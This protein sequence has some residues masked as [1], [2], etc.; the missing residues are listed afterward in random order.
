VATLR[1]ARFLSL[2]EAEGPGR[3]CA[4]WLQGC[5]LC[6]PGCCNPA[7]WDPAGGREVAVEEL[8]GLL[9]AA[10]GEVEGL[11]LLGGEPFLQA[12]GAAAVARAARAL[13]L[14]VVTFTGHR[15]EELVAS[16]DPDTAALLAATDLLVDGPYLAQEPERER[17]WAGSANQRFHYLTDRYRPGLE[18]PG[19]G[20]PQE[21][22]EVHLGAD[23]RLLRSGWPV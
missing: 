6:C 15:R 23:G 13:G 14:S 9:R 16:P 3:R 19:P 17:R 11:T 20:E 8:A 5:R 22:V 10:R 21:T 7:M 4:L 12:A 2:T 18:R 1:V